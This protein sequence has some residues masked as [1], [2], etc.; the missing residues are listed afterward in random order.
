[1]NRFIQAKLLK[2]CFAEGGLHHGVERVCAL[3]E[4][5]RAEAVHGGWK[6]QSKGERFV[7]MLRIQ[8]RDS[9]TSANTHYTA[10]LG[11]L[12][13]MCLGPA[14]AAG[15][16]IQA[17]ANPPQMGHKV[18]PP[19]PSAQH[20]LLALQKVWHFDSPYSQGIVICDV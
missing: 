19:A 18:A 20:S 8:L 13:T 4:E 1:M 6:G 9:L 5:F 15:V 3:L 11:G 14:G 16:P 17:G 2:I 12:L 10:A 7:L